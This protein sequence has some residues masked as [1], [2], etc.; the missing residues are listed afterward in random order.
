MMLNLMN[1]GLC[2]ITNIEPGLDPIHSW[3]T[4]SLTE[5]FPIYKEH[6]AAQADICMRHA[7]PVHLEIKRARGGAYYVD[8]LYPVDFSAAHQRCVNCLRIADRVDVGDG[9]PYFSCASCHHR[10]FLAAPKHQVSA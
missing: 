6:V 4:T 2:R 5:H 8:G 3:V 7:L 10:M 9:A 1:Q